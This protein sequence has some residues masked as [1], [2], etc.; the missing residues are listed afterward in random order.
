MT[1]YK[2][3]KVSFDYADEF[4]CQEF[5]MMTTEEYDDW[6][7]DIEER[8]ND[9]ENEF[10]F[11]TNEFLEFESFD[12]FKD[13]LTVYDLPK[14]DYNIFSKYFFSSSFGTSGLF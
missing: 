11:G 3:V 9:G 5:K 6:I 4:Q 1:T 8:I 2:L 13:G 12:D 10:Y 7:K 14:E